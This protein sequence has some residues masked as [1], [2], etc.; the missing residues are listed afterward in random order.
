MAHLA[1]PP[2]TSPIE[3]LVERFDPQVFDVGRPEARIRVEGAEPDPCVVVLEDGRARL[4]DPGGRID[5]ELIADQETW[6]SLARDLRDGMAAFRSG[7]LRIRRDLHLGVGFLAATASPTGEGRLCIRSV[8][9][10]AGSLSTMDAGSGQPIILAHGLGA[11]KASFLPTVAALAPGYR[12]IAIDLPGF[13][14]S[15]KPLR[16]AY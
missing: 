8:E 15:D 9:T 14:D 5:A 4:T 1:D 11:T 10:A 2:S 6:I 12:T 13:G 7:G 3:Q 16:G